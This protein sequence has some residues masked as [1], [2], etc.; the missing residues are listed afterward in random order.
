MQTVTVV[1][2]TLF[3]VALTYL[4]DGTQWDRIAKLNGLNDPFLTGI[5][6]LQIPDPDPNATGGVYAFT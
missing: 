6:T 2:G 5:V 3:E 1:G 4:N